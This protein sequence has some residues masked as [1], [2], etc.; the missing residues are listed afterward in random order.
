MRRAGR[1]TPQH[2]RCVFGGLMRC[3]PAGGTSSPEISRADARSPPP[4][5]EE[6]V[7]AKTLPVVAF[8]GN[9]HSSGGFSS[10]S[11]ALEPIYP[12]LRIPIGPFPDLCEHVTPGV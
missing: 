2:R 5:R 7:R 1:R 6:E 12:S 4:L 3:L 11:Y 8:T 10:A 9:R